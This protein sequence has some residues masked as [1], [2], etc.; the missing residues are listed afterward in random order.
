LVRKASEQEIRARNLEQELKVA[1]SSTGK[2]EADSLQMAALKRENER[3]TKK[4]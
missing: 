1:R 3:L 4:C 2:A